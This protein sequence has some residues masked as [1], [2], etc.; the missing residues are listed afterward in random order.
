MGPRDDEGLDCQRIYQFRFSHV[1]AVKKQAVWQEIAAWMH[2]QLG[3]PDI[4]LEPGC[5]NMEFL[6]ACQAKEKWGIDFQKPGHLGGI[7]YV[8]GDVL[9]VELPADYFDAIFLS[10]FLEH[11]HSPEEV[12]SLLKKLR[13]SLKG[14]GKIAVIGPNFK[15]CSREYFDCADHRLCLTELSVAEHLFAAGFAIRK[16]IPRFLPFSFRSKLPA[17][18]LLTKFYLRFPLAWRVWGKQF[19]VVG[20]KALPE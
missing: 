16:V 20:Q 11:L 7:K 18:A 6:Q 3:Y 1:D 15:Y 2:S 9:A 12:Y 8:Q 14:E 5:G 4:L 19:L 13:N 17:S 10:N